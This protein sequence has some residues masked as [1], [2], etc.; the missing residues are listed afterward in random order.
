MHQATPSDKSLDSRPDK[1]G[2]LVRWFRRGV[3]WTVR[4]ACLLMTLA[5]IFVV[6]AW[7]LGNTPVNSDFQSAGEEGIEIVILNNGVHA[8]IVVPLDHPEFR[9]LDYL[10]PSHFMDPSPECR[11]AL[12][13]WGNRHF[14]METRTWND[15]KVMTV[16]KAFAGIGDTVVHVELCS[17]NSWDSERSRRIRISPDQFR[18]LSVFLLETMKTS[19]DGKLVPVP[20]AHYHDSDAFYEAKGSYHLFR[21]CNVWAGAGLKKAGIRVGYWTVTPGLLLACLPESQ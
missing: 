18:K 21:T 15:V 6:A 20:N 4:A 19:E 16:L 5:L 13:G 7:V 14:Y 1:Q 17:H 8:D 3:R 9:W 12:F 11:Y 10:A 2:S